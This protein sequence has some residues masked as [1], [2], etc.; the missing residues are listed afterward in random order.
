MLYIIVLF[1]WQYDLHIYLRYSWIVALKRIMLLNTWT[2]SLLCFN[3]L[4]RILCNVSIEYDIN[5]YIYI[6]IYIY[7][8]RLCFNVMWIHLA[9]L[10]LIFCKLNF[11]FYGNLI[12][13]Q[14]VKKVLVVVRKNRW[15]KNNNSGEKWYFLGIL[16]HSRY[17]S[18]RT[19]G[20]H[21][22]HITNIVCM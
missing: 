4:V 1:G 20:K 2:A 19:S 12:F 5:I 15:L 6:Y 9:I 21:L 22:T 13:N 17:A 18:K 10:F 11:I 8:P 16:Q 7:I 14:T 3:N